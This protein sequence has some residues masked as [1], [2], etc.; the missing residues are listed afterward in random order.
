ML[1]EEIEDESGSSTE[2]DD[3]NCQD[4][5]HQISKGEA[6]RL[7]AEAGTE[8]RG[9]QCPPKLTVLPNR[10]AMKP[11]EE[12]LIQ[13]AKEERNIDFE[14]EDFQL[15]ALLGIYQIICNSSFSVATTYLILTINIIEHQF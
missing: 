10:L 4:K 6:D 7:Y 13:E 5:V 1:R 12:V 11:H 3:T 2:D 14:L 9:E 15:Q 8:V